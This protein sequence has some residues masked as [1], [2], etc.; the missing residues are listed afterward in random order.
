MIWAPIDQEV[1]SSIPGFVM[2]VFSSREL[3]HSMYGVDVCVFQCSL[4]MFSPVLFLEEA[5]ATFPTTCEV[6]PSNCVHAP[7]CVP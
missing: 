1:L 4:S 6:R 7:M 2:R 3:F 5:P